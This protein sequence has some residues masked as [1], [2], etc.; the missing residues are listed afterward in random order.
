LDVLVARNGEPPRFLGDEEMK[1]L[2]ERSESIHKI[3]QNLISPIGVLALDRLS[4]ARD[5]QG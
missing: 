1:P 2:C 3:I 5:N 4:G